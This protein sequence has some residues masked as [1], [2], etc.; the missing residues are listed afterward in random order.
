MD[1]LIAVVG[2]IVVTLLFVWLTGRAASNARPE[3]E[4]LS[5]SVLDF[6]KAVLDAFKRKGGK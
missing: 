3:L 6:K 4:T 1:I 5:R 2:Y